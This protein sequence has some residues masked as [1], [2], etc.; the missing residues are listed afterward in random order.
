MDKRFYNLGLVIASITLLACSLF[1]IHVHFDKEHKTHEPVNASDTLRFKVRELQ[2]EITQLKH[3]RKAL[4]SDTAQFYDKYN[5]ILSRINSNKTDSAQYELLRELLNKPSPEPIDINQSIAGGLLCC[6]LLKNTSQQ[7]RF[8]D[9]VA[10]LQD[11][12]IAT[13]HSEISNCNELLTEVSQRETLVS[14]QLSTTKRKLR[15]WRIF[16]ASQL[17]AIIASITIYKLTH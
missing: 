10:Q 12:I 11:T 8:A 3:Q 17:S 9:S 1:A 7:L 14:Q 2:D 13:Q 6:S 4:Q 15:G 5:E 16:G